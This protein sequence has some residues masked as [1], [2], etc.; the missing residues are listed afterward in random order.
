[1]KQLLNILSLI[2]TFYSTCIY[3]QNTSE[4]NLNSEMNR[5]ETETVIVLNSQEIDYYPMWSPNS[6]FIAFNIN[7][8]WNKIRLD[9]IEFEAVKWRGQKIGF[10]ISKDA[11]TEMSEKEIDEFKKV[12]KFNAR[13]VTSKNGTKIELPMQS[14]RTSLVVTHKGENPKTLWTSGGENCHSLVL[15]PNEK[16][17][18]YLCELNGLLIMKIE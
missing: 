3:S 16:Y 15:S 6:D 13:E 11:I 9:N 12:S 18:A 8:K 4:K 1:M 17:V 14:L 7:E 10:L 2:L 5:L